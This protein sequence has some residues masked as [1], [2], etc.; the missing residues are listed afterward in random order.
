MEQ[1]T[2]AP[3]IE[4]LDALRAGQFLIVV[5]DADRENE[6][7]LVFAAQFATPEKLAFIIR[8]TGG[9]VCLAL[10]NVIADKLELP[11]MVTDNTS[12]RATPFTVSIEA[13]EGV[14]TGISARDRATTILKSIH[15]AAKPEDLSR[16]GHVFPLRAQ[17][18][19]VLWRTGHT[20][21]S[22]DLCRLSGL[23][24]GAVISELMHEDGTVMRVPALTEFAKTHDIKMISIADLV[25]YRR[26]TETF[27]RHEAKTLLETEKGTWTF[28]VFDDVLHKKQHTALTMGDIAATNPVLVRMHSECLTGDVFHSLH[29][30]CGAQLD[31]AMDMIR[32]EGTG[33]IVYLR[34]EGR[35]IGLANKIRAYELQHAKG[36]DTVDANRALGFQ[37]DLREYGIGAQ[38]LKELGVGKMRLLTNNP[39]KI[40]GLEGYGL[41]AIEQVPLQ[42]SVKSE[43][44]KKYLMTKK[45]KLQHT[46]SFD[47]KES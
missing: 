2:F 6:G 16:P 47:E 9:V 22:V 15:P 14:E 33:V 7:D 20:E 24:E 30:D 4:A 34:Q 10:S 37:D 46:I 36:M 40:V 3:V 18:G 8:H 41:E 12:K 39:K 21:A 25:A 31:R 42:T 26:R 43:R 38:I 1:Q 23:R 45:E 11:A 17:D 19:G 27:V 32:E 13:R 29:C 44:Q 35:G 5:D 28:H